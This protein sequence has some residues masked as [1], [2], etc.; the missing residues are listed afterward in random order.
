MLKCDQARQLPDTIAKDHIRRLVHALLI[1]LAVNRRIYA[2]HCF[3]RRRRT[4]YRNRFE[5]LFKSSP[6]LNLEIRQAFD[7]AS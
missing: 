6:R 1:R 3:T 7:H 2:D 5:R 4:D